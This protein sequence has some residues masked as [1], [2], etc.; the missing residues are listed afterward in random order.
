M[1]VSSGGLSDLILSYSI[2]FYLILSCLG[3]P[4]LHYIVTHELKSH[5][6]FRGPGLAL[7]WAMYI[8]AGVL[9]LPLTDSV[10]GP[11]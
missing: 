11:N 7:P 1:S 4:S 10:A 2:L 5:K 8:Y 3:L 9:C 6:K